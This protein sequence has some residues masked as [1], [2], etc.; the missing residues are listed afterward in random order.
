[1]LGLRRLGALWRAVRP[2]MRSAGGGYPAL[3]RDRKRAPAAIQRGGGAGFSALV[4]RGATA[5]RF[6]LIDR[7]EPP[8]PR[9]HRDWRTGSPIS[10][11]P[12]IVDQAIVG[13]LNTNVFDVCFAK[14]KRLQNLQHENAKLDRCVPL[15]K[16]RDNPFLRCLTV[17]FNK[18]FERR[19]GDQI[20]AEQL[21]LSGS[22][23]AFGLLCLCP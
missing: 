5:S 7:T 14:H 15:F 22:S 3:P 1:M 23:F 2:W 19:L 9:I 6:S 8:L 16:Q 21:I 20:R 11:F 4:L 10:T 12:R 18:L 17:L 13:K